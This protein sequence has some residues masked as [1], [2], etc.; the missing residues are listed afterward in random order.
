[1]EIKKFTAEQPVVREEIKRKLKDCWKQTRIGTQATRTCGIIA[2][3]V[4]RGRFIALQADITMEEGAYINNLTAQL[5]KQKMVLF[6]KKNP[7]WAGERK[8]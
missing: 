1:M 2:K 4:L 3:A 8:W 6:G 7:K 5:E